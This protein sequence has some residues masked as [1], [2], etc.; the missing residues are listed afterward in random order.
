MSVALSSLQISLLTALSVCAETHQKQSGPASP[1][2]RREGWAQPPH[3]LWA[4]RRLNDTSSDPK[5]NAPSVFPLI[6]CSHFGATHLNATSPCHVRWQMVWLLEARHELLCY[7][8]SCL[9]KA[10]SL[11]SVLLP[12][13]HNLCLNQWDQSRC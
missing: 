8:H 7:L 2:H 1:S 4:K 6:L 10:I 12:K 13:T 3:S 9:L 11:L 5:L